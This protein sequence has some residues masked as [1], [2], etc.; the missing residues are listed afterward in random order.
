MSQVELRQPASTQSGTQPEA[1]PRV[2]LQGK[3]NAHPLLTPKNEITS[4]ESFGDLRF[5][6]TSRP[7]PDRAQA[8]Q[9]VMKGKGGE[10]SQDV[11]LVFGQQ[12]GARDDATTHVS[13]VQ[14]EAGT[15]LV[16]VG[17]NELSDEKIL[18]IVGVLGRGQEA[19]VMLVGSSSSPIVLRAPK[20]QFEEGA[21]YSLRDAK[22]D[23]HRDMKLLLATGVDVGAKRAAVG[24]NELNHLVVGVVYRKVDTNFQEVKIGEQVQ[25]RMVQENDAA[26]AARLLTHELVKLHGT[27]KDGQRHAHTDYHPRQIGAI[28]DREGRTFDV[29]SQMSAE[30]GSRKPMV[31]GIQLLDAGSILGTNDAGGM[32]HLPPLSPIGVSPDAARSVLVA[33]QANDPKL[34]EAFVRGTATQRSAVWQVGAFLYHAAMKEMPDKAGFARIPQQS[35]EW[36]KLM[37]QFETK[38]QNQYKDEEI[39]LRHKCYKKTISR[40]YVE[41]T[42]KALRGETDLTSLERE[43]GKIANS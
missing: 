17:R 11:M 32:R 15:R 3:A 13:G 42:M 40:E 24:K 1:G 41:V 6:E 37:K 22:A 20:A 23:F 25:G 19:D 26:E 8:Q 16:E 12:C 38:A 21:Q 5:L 43:L 7:M 36:G 4:S 18:P 35:S 39:R 2:Q 10:R 30:I 29:R 33:H 9:S 31:V 14:R 34:G 28:L 27:G